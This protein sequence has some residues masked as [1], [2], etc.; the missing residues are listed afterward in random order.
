MLAIAQTMDIGLEEVALLALVGVETIP[1]PRTYNEA[2]NHPQYGSQWRAAIQEE[3]AS[4]VA[5]NT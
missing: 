5:N 4:L 1:L 2:I 3:I